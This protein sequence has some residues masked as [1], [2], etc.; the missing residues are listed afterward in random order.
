MG[1]ALRRIAV[2]EREI[3]LVPQYRRRPASIRTRID[4]WFGTRPVQLSLPY[5]AFVEMA[6]PSRAVSHAEDSPRG[7]QAQH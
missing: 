6:P 5:L 4:R 7:S 2:R 1:S 3:V